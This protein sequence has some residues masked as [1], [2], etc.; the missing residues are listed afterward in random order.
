MTALSAERIGWKAFTAYSK[1][2]SE[3]PELGHW[4]LHNVAAGQRAVI[5]EGPYRGIYLHQ[6]V[7]AWDL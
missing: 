5:F 6:Q 4:H 3:V 1:W 7:S 2:C